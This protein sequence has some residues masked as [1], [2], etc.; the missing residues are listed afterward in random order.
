M[1][2]EKVIRNHPKTRGK[3]AESEA[4]DP[5]EELERR[6][7]ERINL[8]SEELNPYS[9][10]PELEPYTKPWAVCT[11]CRFSYDI[12]PWWKR[13][14]RPP[15]SRDLFCAAAPRAKASHP[16]TGR[17]TYTNS[18][19]ST[20]SKGFSEPHDRCQD[21]NLAGYCERFATKED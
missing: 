19:F 5:L 7:E 16:V 8:A 11:N 10:P 21:V 15:Q 2:D 20:P 6:A 17:V 4:P 9:E 1:D 18:V 12:R 14:L 3:W 13:L